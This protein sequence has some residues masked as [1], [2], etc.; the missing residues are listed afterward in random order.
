M[1]VIVSCNELKLLQL[2]AIAQWLTIAR[3]PRL[4]P[5]SQYLRAVCDPIPILSIEPP[6]A[7]VLF[8]SIQQISVNI[9]K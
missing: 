8:E 1:I 3:T 5:P 2:I 6:S 4:T 9:V 7:S